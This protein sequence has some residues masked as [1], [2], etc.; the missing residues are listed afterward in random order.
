MIGEG[1]LLINGVEEGQLTP[2]QNLIYYNSMVESNEFENMYRKI[3]NIF[4]WSN[5]FKKGYVLIDQVSLMK[6]IK[7]KF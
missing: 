4:V 7:S 6:N 5:F 1:G 2:L 3:L